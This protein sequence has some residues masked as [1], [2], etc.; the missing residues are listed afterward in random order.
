M[1]VDDVA[2]NMWLSRGEGRGG[3]G[4]GLQ[5]QGKPV[6]VDPIKPTFKAP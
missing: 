4:G 5:Q 2:S 3:K 6:Q 1:R